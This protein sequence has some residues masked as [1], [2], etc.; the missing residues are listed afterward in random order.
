MIEKKVICPAFARPRERFH[1]QPTG[2]N[3][4]VNLAK[5]SV[6]N[7]EFQLHTSTM[8]EVQYIALGACDLREDLLIMGVLYMSAIEYD[9]DGQAIRGNNSSLSLVCTCDY[10]GV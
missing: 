4:K 6:P 9:Q 10:S 2:F 7:I 1:G 3:S 8:A 5:C